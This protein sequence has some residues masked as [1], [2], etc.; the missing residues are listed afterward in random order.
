MSVLALV[1]LA[2]LTLAIAG[3]VYQSLGLAHDARQFP[4]RGQLVDVGG[5]RLH[6]VCCGHGAP[7]VV[8]ESALAASSLS[9]ARVQ[10][11]VARFTSVCAYDRAGFGWSDASTIP[12]TFARTLDELHAVLTQ[13]K[14]TAPCVMVGHSF[15]VFVC[16][17]YAAR[18]PQTVGGLVLVDPPTEW[19]HAD[20]RQVRLLWGAVQL[21]RLGGLLARLGV[22]RVCLALL[23][24]GAPAAPRHFV[25]VFGP[26]TARTL[27]RLVGEVRKLPPEIHPVVQ[28]LWCQ[29]KCFQAMADQL[30]MLE[31]AT[32]SA[33]EVTSLGDVPLVVISSA[34]QTPDVTASHHVLA[35]MSSQGHV[36]LA[37]KSG[38]WV[39]Y[40]EPEL[41]V[42]TIREVVETVRRRDSSATR[43][44]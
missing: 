4:P 28:A 22:V 9:W 39:P 42:E 44:G 32:A 40:D 5:Y 18:Y 36:V 41:I 27:E 3:V 14:C 34:D 24:G 19:V 35:R 21:S 16:L 10:P 12:R 13:L 11:D 7:T 43:P 6:A 29:P 31:D 15:G 26:M 33:A 30:R 20:H 25:K 37:S 2:A 17:A 38:H 23:T 8:L 1:G